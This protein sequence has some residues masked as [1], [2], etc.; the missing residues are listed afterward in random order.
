M[1][2]IARYWTMHFEAGLI[3]AGRENGEEQWVGSHEAWERLKKL[4]ALE[5]FSGTARLF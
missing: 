4:E 5:S 1:I 3:Y 2:H